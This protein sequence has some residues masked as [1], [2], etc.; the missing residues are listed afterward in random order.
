[1]PEAAVDFVFQFGAEPQEISGPPRAAV[2]FIFHFGNEVSAL[3]NR[4][5]AVD[6]KFSLRVYDNSSGPGSGIVKGGE[7]HPINILREGDRIKIVSF[8]SGLYGV[9]GVADII[10]RKVVPDRENQEINLQVTPQP[11]ESLVPHL[12]GGDDIRHK[13]SRNELRKLG[14]R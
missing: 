5:A 14:Q 11:D 4:H 13:P 7:T 12:E 2:D 1:M 3:A 6:F 10:S 9:N 8:K